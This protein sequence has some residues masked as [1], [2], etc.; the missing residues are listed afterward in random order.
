[1]RTN[2]NRRRGWMA[3]IVGAVCELLYGPTC[4]ETNPFKCRALHGWGCPSGLRAI[5]KRFL[6]ERK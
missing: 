3:W 1:M 5:P 2:C 6:D 4:T